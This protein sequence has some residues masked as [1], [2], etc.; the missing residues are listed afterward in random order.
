MRHAQLLLRLLP[1]RQRTLP[2]PDTI[3]VSIAVPVT[4]TVPL[5]DPITDSLPDGD[6]GKP[7]A[8]HG[9]GLSH[10]PGGIPF[11]VPHRHHRGTDRIPHRD[12]RF[13][14]RIAHRNRGIAHRIAITHGPRSF[15]DT[16]GHSIR[17]A[18]D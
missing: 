15:T 16:L 5:P 2:H 18:D 1:T 6:H 17:I 14:H 4:H 3:A 7:D 13:A 11:T 10:G 9:I 8:Q 12:R